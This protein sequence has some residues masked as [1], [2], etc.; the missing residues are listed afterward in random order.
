MAHD[1]GFKIIYYINTYNIQQHFSIGFFMWFLSVWWKMEDLHSVEFL[2]RVWIN[3]WY[4][5]TYLNYKWFSKSVG[6]YK[7]IQKKN[8]IV[9]Y[10]LLHFSVPPLGELRWKPARTQHSLKHCWNGTYLAHNHSIPCWQYYRNGSYGGSEDCLY[11]SVY[12]PKGK[13][14][15][16]NIV[17]TTRISVFISFHM[18]VLKLKGIICMFVYENEKRFFK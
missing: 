18:I 4:A 12:T 7:I 17:W 14:Y 11:L 9:F 5:L 13:K 6:A 1:S 3:C 8:Y 2:M 15:L 16:T 10:I